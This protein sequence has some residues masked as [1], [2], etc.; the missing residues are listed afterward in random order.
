[1]GVESAS[2]AS[3]TTAS[4]EVQRHALRFR[5]LDDRF[6]GAQIGIAQRLADVDPCAARNV[7]AMRRRS[8]TS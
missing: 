4:V 5:V 6:R 3:A 8:R 1:L 2:N 7:F